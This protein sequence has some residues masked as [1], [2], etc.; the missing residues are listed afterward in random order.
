MNRHDARIRSFCLTFDE[1]LHWQAVATWLEMLIVTRGDSLLR[2]KGIL[3]IAGQERPIAI[4]GVQH[5]LHPPAPLPAWPKRADGSDDRRSRIVF[6]VR[7]L[8][9]AVVEDGLRAFNLAAAK[10][11]AVRAGV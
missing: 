5:L 11:A 2:I 9:P 4:H 7:D 3:D 8:E 6:I 10:E 1:A